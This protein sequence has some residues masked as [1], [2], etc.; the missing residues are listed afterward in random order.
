M[1]TIITIK[2]QLT[3]YCERFWP[4]KGLGK[5]NKRSECVLTGETVS[6]ATINVL[7]VAIFF[8]NFNIECGVKCCI[9]CVVPFFKW[10]KE[11]LKELYFEFPEKEAAIFY[12]A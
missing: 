9:S 2:K 4:V 7:C 8:G 3:R 11:A 1:K 10:D 12:W 5:R 6:K